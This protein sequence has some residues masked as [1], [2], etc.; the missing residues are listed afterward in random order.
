MGFQHYTALI[1]DFVAIFLIDMSVDHLVSVA[2]NGEVWV[3][4]DHHDLYLVR[5]SLTA[6]TRMLNTV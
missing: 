1:G 4:S 6:G 5:A 3:V 2:Y